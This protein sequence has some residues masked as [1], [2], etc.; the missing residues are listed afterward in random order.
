MRKVLAI[1]MGLALAG[2]ATTS[3]QVA[4]TPAAAGE[5]TL[6]AVDNQ[7]VPQK[8]SNGDEVISGLLTLNADGTFEVRTQLRTMMT[9][10]QP[11]TYSRVAQGLYQTSPI[12]LQL[13]WQAGTET[14]GAFFGRT[15]R[16]YHNG[17]EYLYLK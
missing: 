16:F 14:S 3:S 11:L 15:L 2:C 8:I 5:Y 9:S 6:I 13:K 7:A 10:A 1:A 4:N 17:V 12:G